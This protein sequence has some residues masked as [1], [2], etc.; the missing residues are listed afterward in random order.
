MPED[1]KDHSQP[2]AIIQWLMWMFQKSTWRK[3]PCFAAL[4]L[5]I[6]LFAIYE[7]SSNLYGRITSGEGQIENDASGGEEGKDGADIDGGTNSV[8]ATWEKLTVLDVSARAA[9]KADAEEHLDRHIVSEYLSK[10][11]EYSSPGVP[12]YE[13]SEDVENSRDKGDRWEARLAEPQVFHR[14]DPPSPE[15]EYRYEPRV[16]AW[17]RTEDDSKRLLSTKL[18]GIQKQGWEFVSPKE[19]RHIFSQDRNRVPGDR[20]EARLSVPQVFRRKKR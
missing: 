18:V 3:H 9:T 13:Y 1:Y 12:L 7:G 8:R 6:V 14:R 5:I 15:Y 11:W 19:P 10:G 17:A 4:A 16:F 20:W 2:P